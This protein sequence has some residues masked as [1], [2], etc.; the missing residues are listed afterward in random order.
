MDLVFRETTTNSKSFS[1]V[2]YFST[3]SNEVVKH[4]TNA[5]VTS[6]WLI[7]VLFSIDMHNFAS[8]PQQWQTI[9]AVVNWLLMDQYQKYINHSISHALRALIMRYAWYNPG[10]YGDNNW[11][12]YNST[13]EATEQGYTRHT[14]RIEIAR[15]CTDRVCET[16]LIW[17][18]LFCF[19]YSCVSRPYMTDCYPS[20]G[21]LQDE[22]N[23]QNVYKMGTRHIYIA[24]FNYKITVSKD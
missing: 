16:I 13:K 7:S 23:Q 17:C 21:I 24:K 1:V 15:L 20:C 11:D 6:T 14:H 8:S 18:C 19:V 9:F 2:E 5:T 12:I 10:W 4:F 3:Y 22:V